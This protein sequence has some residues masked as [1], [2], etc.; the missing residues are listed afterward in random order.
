VPA[1]AAFEVVVPAADEG[2]VHRA[3]PAD[4]AG[5]AAYLHDQICASAMSKASTS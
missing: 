1:G 2:F 4:S 5:D 3:R